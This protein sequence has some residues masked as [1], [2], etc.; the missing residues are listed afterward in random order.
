MTTQAERAMT[1]AELKEAL[2]AHFIRPE[3]R[4]SQAGAGAIFLTEVTAPGPSTRRA[5]AVHVGLW[6]SRGG[7]RID[8]CELKTSR[9]DWLRELENPQ[10]AEAWWPYCDA[11]WLVVP[12]A[13]IVKDSE[14]PDGWGLMMP[15]ARSRRFQ[16]VVKPQERKAQLTVLLL[17]TLLTSTETVKVNALRQQEQALRERFD[18]QVQRLRQSRTSMS[19]ANQ[20]RLALLDRFEEALG[21][22]LEDHPWGG[23][24]LP[25]T[26]AEALK[27]VAEGQAAT[28]KVRRD[29]EYLLKDLDRVA[30]EAQRGADELRSALGAEK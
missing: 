6:Q 3:D 15:K 29:A 22:K 26:A 23:G 7:G 2:H 4:V 11:F 10:K 27:A 17:R 30:K 13:G 28:D 12:H 16:V 24:I 8:V 1:T 20:S 19:S 9:A 5:D 14:L 18:D 21:M 25:E